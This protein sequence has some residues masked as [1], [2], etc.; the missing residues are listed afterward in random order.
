MISA[1]VEYRIA[2]YFFRIYLPEEVMLQIVDRLIPTCICSEDEDLDHDELV[3][4]AVDIID[5]QLEDKRFK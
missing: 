4:W 5:E 3:R 1:E 2:F